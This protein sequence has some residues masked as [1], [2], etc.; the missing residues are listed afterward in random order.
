MIRAGIIIEDARIELL[1]GWM[2]PKMTQNPPHVV[3]SELV[4]DVVRG[5]VQ[6]AGVFFRN[7]LF[8]SARACRNPT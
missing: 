3:A 5:C 6:S 8:D 7:N 2:V 4:R 1:D